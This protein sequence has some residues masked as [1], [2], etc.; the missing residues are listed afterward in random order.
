MS[1]LSASAEARIGG[2]GDDDMPRLAAVAVGAP[3]Y[4]AFEDNAAA[5][6]GAQR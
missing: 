5:D 3:H 4:L 6:A 1:A 2:G